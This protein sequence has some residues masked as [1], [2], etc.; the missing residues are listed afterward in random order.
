[1]KLL[2]SFVTVILSVNMFSQ[3]LDTNIHSQYLVDS[4]HIKDSSDILNSIDT[5][6]SNL[7]GTEILPKI[8]SQIKWV[9]DGIRHL[10]IHNGEDSKR[11]ILIV[12]YLLAAFIFQK[13]ILIAAKNFLKI[14][15]K[16]AALKTI[17]IIIW[18]I[19]I[20]LSL[21]ETAKYSY[22][23]FYAV[24][25]ALLISASPALTNYYGKIYL[26]FRKPFQIGDFIKTDVFY[27]EVKEMGWR[28]V[29]L[30][31]PDGAI[32]HAPNSYFIKNYF[33]NVNIGQKE[34]F[35][36]LEFV[37]PIEYDPIIIKTILKECA[38]SSPYTFPR[39]P[40]QIFL[41]ETDYIKR[42]NKYKIALYLFDSRYENEIVSSIN[43]KAL[44]EVIDVNF[45]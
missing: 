25:A 40:V 10:N 24:L 42:I 23:L 21:F 12:V 44:K 32:I 30:Q 35:L 34:Q 18:T 8:N 43:E 26:L 15:S 27:G 2:I 17:I 1:M 7:E 38:I 36:N 29:R 14:Y 22:A 11:F 31:N 28:A 41:E 20:A 37:F 4:A 6:N 19:A 9:N 3:D 16:G 45:K 13:L 33:E 39:K 5:A